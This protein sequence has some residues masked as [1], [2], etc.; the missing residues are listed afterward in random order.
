MDRML[1]L[2]GC[3]SSDEDKNVEEDNVEEDN[4]EEEEV[5][6]IVSDE[7]RH[8]VLSSAGYAKSEALASTDTNETEYLID[9][10]LDKMWR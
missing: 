7:G 2:M 9:I 6:F 3:L 5:G 10:V 1:G 4:V 8:V